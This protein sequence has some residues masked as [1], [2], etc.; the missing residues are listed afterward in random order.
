MFLYMLR[1]LRNCRVAV[2]EVLF[3]ILSYQGDSSKYPKHM[4]LRRN[5]EKIHF[6]S[7]QYQPKISPIFNIFKVQIW[8]NLCMEMFL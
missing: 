8:G 4:I 3:S 1:Y 2:L 5:I 6:L 7:I